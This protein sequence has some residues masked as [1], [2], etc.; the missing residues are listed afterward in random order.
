MKIDRFRFDNCG[1]VFEYSEEHHA[2]IFI[3]KLNGRSEQEFIEDVISEE[4]QKWQRKGKKMKIEFSLEKLWNNYA[5]SVLPEN[6]GLTQYRETRNAF[7]GGFI[8]CF[9]FLTNVIPELSD[10]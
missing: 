7:Y 2:Y 3:G 5:D 6:C 9:A 4:Q 10:E 8:Q 1:S